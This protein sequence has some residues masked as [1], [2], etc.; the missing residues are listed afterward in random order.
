MKVAIG[1]FDLVPVQR[2]TINYKPV[3]A[4][5]DLKILAV[6]RRFVHGAKNRIKKPEVRRKKGN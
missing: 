1:Y 2:L 3:L 5:Y 6:D 4:G